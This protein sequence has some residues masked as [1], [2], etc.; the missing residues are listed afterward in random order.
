MHFPRIP[1]PSINQDTITGFR[2]D[3]PRVLN[4]LPGQ[5]RK[6]FTFQHGPALHLTEPVLL[7]VAGVPDP[8]D[9]EIRDVE[10]SKGKAVPSI[11]G[12]MVIGEV[13][14]AVAVGEWYTGQIPEDKHPTPFLMVH[15]P[16][17]R[18]WYLLYTLEGGKRERRR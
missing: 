5:L 6:G 7:A 18:D 17:I 15:V 4:S 9:E 1:V 16:A 10:C 2:L 11:G 13:D 12:R 3:G 8:V 14:G